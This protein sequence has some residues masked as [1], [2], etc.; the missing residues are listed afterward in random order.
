[1]SNK[2]DMKLK[3][4]IKFS[5]LMLIGGFVATVLG[6]IQL[7]FTEPKIG[8]N[9]KTQQPV[10]INGSVLFLLGVAFL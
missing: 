10:I 1:M 9:L 2:L 4:F 7:F 3:D 6:F 8:I 5:W